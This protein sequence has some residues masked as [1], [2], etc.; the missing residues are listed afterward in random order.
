M[1][2]QHVRHAVVVLAVLQLFSTGASGQTLGAATIDGSV[3]DTSG[4]VLPGVTVEASSPALIEG[5]RAAVTDAEGRYRIVDLRPGAYAVTF[6]LPGFSTF[7]REGLQLTTGFNAIVNA[8]MAVGTLEETITVTGEAPLVDTRN[9]QEQMTLP[10]EALDA[11]PTTQR[12]AHLAAMVP[13]VQGQGTQYHDV[14]GLGTDRGQQA[15]HG[16]RF[17][18][19]VWNIAG[20]D[21]RVFSGGNFMI[22]THTFQEVVIETLAGGAEASTGGVQINIV[23]RDGGNTFSGSFATEHTYSSWQA[24]NV[25]SDLVARGL[26]PRA[27]TTVK[28]YYDIGGGVGGP[29]VRDRLWFFTAHKYLAKGM[30]QQGN[31]WNALH[32]TMFYQPDRSR[33]G[34]LYDYF[35]DT[36]VRLTW[37]A[38]DKHRIGLSYMTQPSC[39]CQYGLVES[40]LGGAPLVTPEAGGE[41]HYNP[42][43]RPS[44]TWTYPASSRLLLE[45]AAQVNGYFRVQKRAQGVSTTDIA[46]QDIGL[47]LLYGSRNT[48]YSKD[49]R[50]RTFERFSASYITSRHL[51]KFGVD[52]YQGSDGYKSRNDGNQVNQAMWFRF[53]NGVPD[54]VTISATPYGPYARTGAISLYAQDQWTIDRLTLN[55]GL[56]YDDYKAWAPAQHHAAGRF[57]P[58]RDYPAV[59]NVPHFRDLS[60]R[61]GFAYDL[62]GTARTALK[63]A[64]GRYPPRFNDVAMSNPAGNIATSAFRTWTD[65][66]GN[67]VPECVL[68]REVPGANGECGPLSDPNFGLPRGGTNYAPEVLTGFNAQNYNWQ[69]S[70]SVQH[71]LRPGMA[72]NVGYFRTWYGHFLATDN[73]AVTPQDFDAYCITAPADSRLPTSGQELCGLYNIRPDKFGQVN[74]LVRDSSH[75]G[76]QSQIF[77]G[78]DITMNTRFVRGGLLQGGVSVGRTVTDNCIVVDS[79]EVARPGFCNVVPPW[80][81]GTQV[82]LSAIYPLPWGLQTSVIFQNLPGAPITAQYAATNAQIA[83]SLGRNLAGGARSVTVDLIPPGTHFESRINQV[84][85]RATRFFRLGSRFRLQANA[86]LYNISNA[87]NVL[88]MVTSYGANWLQPIQVMGGRLLKVS[89]RVTF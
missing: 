57:V 50:I 71:E 14:G 83:P 20:I 16:Q 25:T 80:S 22:N 40:G 82:K 78:V 17:D 18:D 49:N 15:A 69:S 9:I 37:Q 3:R 45:A 30:Y 11:L 62:F 68:G 32:G 6:T 70:L 26:E 59:D 67:F 42:N 7:R 28:E 87:S 52:F 72:L 60:P 64:L 44:I 51:F 58:A 33:Q 36:S 76:K 29:I 48:G 75:Y 55:L 85:L 88:S 73:L 53:V 74:N 24:S 46:I 34:Y 19:V 2:V 23:P 79:P 77:N 47:G 12:T 31:Y 81:S 86:D 10:R 13:A 65:A 63:G 35:R 21:S 54:R 27:S 89:A 61:L 38:T 43:Y 41:H 84:D 5:A 8:E 1:L 66:N 56:R 39:Q 4:A